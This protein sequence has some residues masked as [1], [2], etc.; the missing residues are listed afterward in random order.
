MARDSRALSKAPAGALLP[1][2]LT[3][4]LLVGC[5]GNDD[6]SGDDPSPDPSATASESPSATPALRSDFGKPA[7]G[8]RMKG[9]TYSYRLPKGWQDA[10][11][12]AKSRQEFVDTAGS[13]PTRTDGFVD[14]VNVGFE[15]APGATLDQLEDSI[16]LQLGSLVKKVQMLPRVSLDG[17]DAIH[18]SGPAELGPDKY[19]LDQFITLEEDGTITI[20]TFSL[21][22]GLAPK[23]RNRLVD[24]V[25]ASW[26]WTD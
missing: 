5:G 23:E 7:T 15:S 1:L 4:T 19:F 8:P 6:T 25:I 20:V 9:K 12:Q 21:S 18:H 24:S 11:K 16:P 14:N 22:R 2:L 26:H 3:A 13:E 10:T 17:I